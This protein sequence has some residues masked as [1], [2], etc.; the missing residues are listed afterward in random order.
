MSVVENFNKTYKSDIR[1]AINTCRN[2]ALFLGLWPNNNNVKKSLLKKS[3]K[4]IINFTSILLMT[5]VIISCILF[6]TFELKLMSQ[7][8]IL[9][10]PTSFYVMAFMKYSII[11]FRSDDLE[12]CLKIIE[13]DW[14]YINYKQRQIM[15]K[16]AKFGRIITIFCA[17][18]MYLGGF[19]FHVISPLTAEPIVTE[20]NISIQPFPSP[21]YGKFLTSGQSP[22]YEI[23]YIAELIVGFIMYSIAITTFSFAAIL[24]IHAC[25]QFEI[26]ILNLDNL[27]SGIEKYSDLHDKLIVTVNSHLKVLSFV[28]QLESV[29][30]EICFIEI[31]GCTLNICLLGYYT[32]MGWK[33]QELS[34]I[35][36]YSILLASFIFN[37]FIYCLI[38]EMVTIQVSKFNFLFFFTSIIF[39]L[40]ATKVGEKSYMINWYLMP[41]K[42]SKDLLF[43][44]RISQYPS[45]ISAG[46]IF[47]LSLGTFCTVLKTSAAYFNALWKMSQ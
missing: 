3:L 21:V 7:R 11:L 25:S 8:I 30:N 24:T 47:V 9:T 2:I 46:K 34:A 18:F 15:L 19:W 28:S 10:G 22:I 27:F 5:F 40:Q 20:K 12:N 6:G 41:K 32:I 44:I 37:I 23:I 38:G 43:F 26:V 45:K 4:L 17:I 14:Q 16:H 36:T 33:K 39:F 42:T 35:L 31:M 29:F 13:N 1:Y